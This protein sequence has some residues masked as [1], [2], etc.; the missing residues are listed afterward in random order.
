MTITDFRRSTGITC[1]Y[2]FTDVEN[3]PLIRKHGLLSYNEL[4]RQRISPPKP[5]GND[6]SRQADEIKGADKFVH[7]CFK[8]EHP[9][10]FKA[11]EDGRIGTTRFLMILIEVI[12]YRGVMGCK[13]VANKSGVVIQPIEQALD[14]IDLKI[15]LDRRVDFSNIDLRNRYNEA[16]KAEVLIP[17]TIPTNLILNLG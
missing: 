12:S 7:L 1:L 14:E 13:D 2:H 10:E 5:G 6:W 3:L 11:K 4:C 8:N 15:L 17:L 9:M 16:K